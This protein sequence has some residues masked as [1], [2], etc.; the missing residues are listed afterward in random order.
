MD[1]RIKLRHLEAFVEISR[2]RSLKRAA[3]VLN[4]TQ[5]AI[6]KTLK[7]L[8]EVLQTP[9][10]HRNRGGVRMTPGGEVFLQSA[11]S[12]LSALEQGLT[13]L[14]RMRDGGPARIA[15]GA[16][17]SVAA[18]VL[19]LASQRFGA[20]L[21]EATLYFEDGPH[22]YL[23]DR[24]RQ[25]ALDLVVGRMGPPA[26]MKGV[27]FVQLYSETV[28]MVVRPGHP[29]G[30][31][32]RLADLQDWPVIFPAK[33]SA[34]R[35]LVDRLLMAEGI[36]GLPNRVETVS[37]AYGRELARST[38]AIWIISEGVVAADIAAGILRK[39]PVDA[40]LTAGPVGIMTR[41]DE[42]PKILVRHFRQAV[43]DAVAA[44]EL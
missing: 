3:E 16:L 21:P 27:S 19:P 31:G 17:P 13:G 11:I 34:I 2:Q 28:A 1:R 44:L 37:G 9:L 7:E 35:P 36:A 25:A 12:S 23:M 30:A 24:L 6:S 14:R 4:L 20:L 43:R 10:M 22:G 8:E 18:R 32:M 33:G 26:S 40:G 42:E 39:L 15:V 38:D 41:A 29:L 5:P